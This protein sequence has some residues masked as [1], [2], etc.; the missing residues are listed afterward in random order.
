MSSMYCPC[1]ATRFALG[2]LIAGDSAQVQTAPDRPLLEIRRP[3]G[4][5]PLVAGEDAFVDH[6][7]NR[8]RGATGHPPR[9]RSNFAIEAP[10]DLD[11][12]IGTLEK[13]CVGINGRTIDFV[14]V[15]GAKAV[16]Q[17]RS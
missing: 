12:M 2:R 17:R 10:A 6:L 7:V 1:R 8:L 3:I 9:W 15:S 14:T 11:D 5:N 16:G 13:L 4:G